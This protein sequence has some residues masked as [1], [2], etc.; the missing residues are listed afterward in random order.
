M[1]RL[2]RIS[3]CTI[4][5]LASIYSLAWWYRA[6]HISDL[7][8]QSAKLLTGLTEMTTGNFVYSKAHVSGFPFRFH[9]QLDSPSFSLTNSEQK[10][11]FYSK[12]P[13][14]IEA[15]PFLQYLTFFLPETIYLR[16][17]ERISSQFTLNFNRPAILTIDIHHSSSLIPPLFSHLF[18]DTPLTIQELNYQ[19]SGFTLTSHTGENLIKTS[20]ND[21]NIRY[22]GNLH[23]SLATHLILQ[24]DQLQLD[25]LTEYAIR[26]KNPTALIP[27]DIVADI[28]FV[29][30]NEADASFMESDIRIN[31]LSYRSSKFEAQA[32]ANLTN[33]FSDPYPYGDIQ[34]ALNQYEAF[35]DYHTSAINYLLDRSSL[36]LPNISRGDRDN[37]KRFIRTLASETHHLERDLLIHFNRKKHDTLYIAN[38]PIDEVVLLLEEYLHP[39]PNMNIR[40]TKRR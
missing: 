18:S 17:N 10:N 13:V 21:L 35:V 23:N 5:L 37:F 20:Y 40:T 14:I 4:L 32:Y 9:I 26:E 34:L 39:A 16:S 1:R 11:V 6:Y 38:R 8:N 27:V 12:D 15:S 36:S 3:V 29:M 24:T 19:D 30:P 25:A 22:R 33:S 7:I 2:C 31:Q 28:V